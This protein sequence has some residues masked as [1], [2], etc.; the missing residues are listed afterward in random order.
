MLKAISVILLALSLCACPAA[1]TTTP[2]PPKTPLQI[3]AT[4]ELDIAQTVGALQ[5]AIINSNSQGLVSDDTTR[6][7]LTITLKVAQAGKQ[8]DAVTSKLSTLGP[9]DKT[10][11][12]TIFN[13][14]SQV[15]TD[16]LNSGLISIKDPKTLA[17]IR[18][19]LTTLQGIIS[20]I[21]S[22]VQ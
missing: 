11:I 15:I 20:S 8:A 19:S 10:N 13:P 5:T 12:L 22:A 21:Q 6:A 18:L 4:A 9:I 1:N 2:A 3:V 17:T 14:I 16:S 7:L